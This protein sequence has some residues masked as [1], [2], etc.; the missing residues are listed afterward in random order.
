WDSPIKEII[1]PAS[2]DLMSRGGLGWLEGFNEFVVRCGLEYAG[3]PGR[4]KFTDN[5]GGEVEMDLS[6]HGRIGNLP[7]SHVEVIVDRDPPHRIRV[8]GAVHERLF[9][10]P[11]L[12]L[13]AEV[14]TVPGDAEFEITDE[15]INHGAYEQEFELIY[16][17]NY[18]RPLLEEGATVHLPAKTVTPIND[19]AARSIN[20]YA[21]Y[22]GPTAGF[23]EQVYLIEP[24]A[25]D[26]QE[27][28][29]L[30]Q[31]AQGQ[32][33][34]SIRWSTAQLPWF[35]LWKNT[36]PDAAGYVTGL[37]PGTNF[38]FNRMVERKAGR[39]GKLKPQQSRQFTL[40]Y[41]LHETTEEVA[42]VR[43][44]IKA[45]QG[46]RETQLSDEPPEVP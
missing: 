39:I 17:S 30:L 23:S 12:E 28:L 11:Q 38:P 21:T 34:A 3:Q 43:R 44:E 15:V 45:I 27:T 10:G 7:A 37:E 36:A 9:Y 14:S 33:G 19:P 13:V 25:N 46:T 26:R 6:L 35:T 4:D 42:K 18:G 8:R 16:H 2:I 41:Q 1:H 22:L 20:Q 5:T 32:C 31:N 24:Y 29:A 40:A